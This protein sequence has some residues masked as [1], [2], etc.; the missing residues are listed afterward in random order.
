M[1]HQKTKL[2]GFQNS[3]INLAPG[4]LNHQSVSMLNIEVPYNRLHQYF[5]LKTAKYVSKRA[6]R[7][8]YNSFSSRVHAVD[9]NT[10][11]DYICN[12]SYD[13]YVCCTCKYPKVKHEAESRSQLCNLS[14]IARITKTEH[15]TADFVEDNR[16]CKAGLS[17]E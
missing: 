8:G 3:K 4:R 15:E 13:W 14:I 10:G 1:S 6:M 2:P 17:I 12:S 5:W 9:C 7:K 16:R 11:Q